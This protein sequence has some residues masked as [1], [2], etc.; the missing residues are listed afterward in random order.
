MLTSMRSLLALA[1]LFGTLPMVSC[2]TNDPDLNPQSSAPDSSSRR[3]P[4]NS[5]VA[6]Q[7]GG[8]LGS[9]PQQQRR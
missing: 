8:A 9:L 5:P 7:G 1:L 2:T 6:G 3:I 4:W